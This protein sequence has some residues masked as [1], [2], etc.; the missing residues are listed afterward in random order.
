MID[1]VIGFIEII[2]LHDVYLAYIRRR[3][4]S[5]PSL[6]WSYNR[7]NRTSKGLGSMGSR[8]ISSNDK[9]LELSREA[10]GGKF[11]ALRELLRFL[12]KEKVRTRTVLRS[13]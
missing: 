1:S 4:A 8:Q 2:C 3:L 13:C 12:R 11:T 5:L 9:L 10:D 7:P 6:A